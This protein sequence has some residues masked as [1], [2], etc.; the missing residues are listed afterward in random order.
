[1]KSL[2]PVI[3]AA[4]GIAAVILLAYFVPKLSGSQS[5]AVQPE[6]AK[7]ANYDIRVQGGPIDYI[8]NKEGK[9]YFSPKFSVVNKG[10]DTFAGYVFVYAQNKAFSPRITGIW[11]YAGLAKR[12][13]KNPQRGYRITIKRM[14]NIVPMVRMTQTP[15]FTEAWVYVYDLDGRKV[16]ETK[17]MGRDL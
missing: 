9:V 5:P 17:I 3:L 10:G 1:M 11:P 7:T 6:A 15:K 2:R 8:R 12:Y 16:N 4:A 14:I 13:P